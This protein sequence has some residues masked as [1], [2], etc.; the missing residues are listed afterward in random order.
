MTEAWNT[1][2][3]EKSESA[4]KPAPSRRRTYRW[5]IPATQV[6]ASP[7][8]A[9]LLIADDHDLVREG[10]RAMLSRESALK[11]IGEAADGREALEL[12]RSLSP[13]LVLMDLRMPRMDGIVATRAI[14]EE[15]PTT[16][17]LVVTIHESPQFLPQAMAAGA[18]GYVLKDATSQ[19]LLEAV[20][21]V[22]DGESSLDQELAIEPL[23]T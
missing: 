12:C 13:D 7:S 2:A 9:R 10:L 6:G 22:L 18:A 16:N 21:W 4:S 19:Q 1:T 20:R 14:R 3:W 23:S 15:C 17:V 11:I 8:P 5:R